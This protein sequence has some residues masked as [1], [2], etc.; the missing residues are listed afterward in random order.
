M[1]YNQ[2]N[3]GIVKKISEADKQI[4]MIMEINQ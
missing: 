3:T 1:I 4:V 2:R